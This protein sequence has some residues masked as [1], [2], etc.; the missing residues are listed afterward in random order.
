MLEAEELLH[1]KCYGSV[2]GS[3]RVK[4][5][6]C[7]EDKIGFFFERMVDALFEGVVDVEFSLVNA[8][9]G[10]FSISGVTKM[11]VCKVIEFHIIVGVCI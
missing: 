7:M 11:G 8:F 9:F 10:D 6:S 1:G 5:V 2:G 4:K 3:D